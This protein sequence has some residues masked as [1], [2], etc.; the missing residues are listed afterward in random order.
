MVGGRCCDDIVKHNHRRRGHHAIKKR[1]PCAKVY[2]PGRRW[3]GRYYGDDVLLLTWIDM[4]AV[5]L[6]F[7]EWEK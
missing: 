3:A 5:L 2:E 1:K 7:N 6:L 4:A